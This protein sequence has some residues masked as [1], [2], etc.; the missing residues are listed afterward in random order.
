MN[1]NEFNSE[2][3]LELSLLKRIEHQLQIAIKSRGFAKLLLSGGSTPMNLYRKFNSFSIDWQKVEIGLVDERWV[4]NESKDSNYKNIKTA[5]GDEIIAEGSF[6]PM[7]YDLESE[8]LNLHLCRKKNNSFLGEKTI[9]LLG[10]GTDGHTASLFP[11]TSSTEMAL[12]AIQ[13]D[14]L[15]NEAPSK[16]KKRITHNLKSLLNTQKLLLYIKGKKKKEVIN[17]AKEN[18]LP[19]SYCINSH[20][21]DLEIFWSP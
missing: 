6:T 20:S 4:E 8:D 21:A 9:V 11:N 17:N 3:T 19:I 1:W 13:P 14:I 2:T 15:T 10:M 12:S 7:V 18:L 16:P 5:L